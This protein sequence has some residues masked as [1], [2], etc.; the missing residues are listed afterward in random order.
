MRQLCYTFILDY[1]NPSF[2]V[3]MLISIKLIECHMRKFSRTFLSYIF[4]LF[5]SSNFGPLAEQVKDGSRILVQQSQPQVQGV[6]PQLQPQQ[7]GS[8]QLPQPVCPLSIIILL[9]LDQIVPTI[10]HVFVFRH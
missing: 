1:E 2:L 10:I 6:Q 7:Q 9:I 8:V 4:L 5:L 3:L